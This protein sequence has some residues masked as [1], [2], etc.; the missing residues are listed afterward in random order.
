[1]MPLSPNPAQASPAPLL[2]GA[3]LYRAGDPTGLWTIDDGAIRLDFEH[4]GAEHFIHLAVPGDRL[5]LESVD[6]ASHRLTARAVTV[7]RVRPL[8]N[9]PAPKD[10][11]LLSDALAWQQRKCIE[12]VRL[13][14][15]TLADRLRHLLSMIAPPSVTDDPDRSHCPIPSLKDIAAIVGAAPE[16]VSRTLG[17]L[18]RDAYLIARRRDSVVVDRR[19][20][21]E[22]ARV[23]RPLDGRTGRRKSD[24]A[25]AADA[26]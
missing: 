5:G 16:S 1:M 10:P 6:A 19:L 25:A 9:P 23:R 7:C 3:I 24:T 15:G 17:E 11:A 18:R 14:S 13:R 4:E 21:G 12:L 26:A 22:A 20:F 8:A 2:P